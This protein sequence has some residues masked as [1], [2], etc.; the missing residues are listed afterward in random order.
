M[1][2]IHTYTSTTFYRAVLGLSEDFAVEQYGC[3]QYDAGTASICLYVV[4]L[5]GGDAKP[6]I[7]T[8]IQLRVTDAKAAYSL[9][10]NRGGKLGDLNSGD[11][12][13]VGFDVFDPD[14]NKLSIAQVP[15]DSDE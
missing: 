2:A 11:D 12:G 14:G 9:I 3:A 10:G 1:N 15:T 6:G 13:T 5:G 4:G 7:D 8:G